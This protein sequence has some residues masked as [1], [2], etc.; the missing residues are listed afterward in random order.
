MEPFP[1][2]AISLPKGSRSETHL[3]ILA[4][5]LLIALAEGPWFGKIVLLI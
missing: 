2:V 1:F 3:V 4:D 5:Y